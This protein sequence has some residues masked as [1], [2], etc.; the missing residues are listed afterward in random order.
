[1]DDD[2][3]KD[4]I[5]AGDYLK[6]RNCSA[7]KTMDNSTNSVR[8]S[9]PRKRKV[10]PWARGYLKSSKRRRSNRTVLIDGQQQDEVNNN[11]IDRVLY[12]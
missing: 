5:D 9:P 4:S 6:S 12:F 1:M 3:T 8:Q 7:L 10:P 2:G 11:E